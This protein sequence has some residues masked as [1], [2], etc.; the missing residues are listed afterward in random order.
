MN[1][2]HFLVHVLCKLL[3]LTTMVCMHKLTHVWIIDVLLN[4]TDARL[5]RPELEEKTYRPL[6]ML[7]PLTLCK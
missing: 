1:K 7:L 5:M 4:N 3:N 2:D 6:S